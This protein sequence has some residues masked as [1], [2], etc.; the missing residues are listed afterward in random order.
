MPRGTL[1]AWLHGAKGPLGPAQ[2]LSERVNKA[3]EVRLVREGGGV[4]RA[5]A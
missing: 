5:C 2:P 3:L 4:K 1:A